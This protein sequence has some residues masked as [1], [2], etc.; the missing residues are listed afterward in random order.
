[1]KK[2][3][4][5]LSFATFCFL[6]LMFATPARSAIVVNMPQYVAAPKAVA[7]HP[8]GDDIKVVHKKKIGWLGIV[9]ISSGLIGLIVGAIPFGIAA[10]AFGIV[11][12]AGKRMKLK[13]LAIA[14]LILG[15]IDIIVGIFLVA[16]LL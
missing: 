3:T 14:G 9:S 16:A 10:M 1:M 5:L 2:T 13:G 11:G 15:A 12:V 7:V 6:L 4:R 8:D